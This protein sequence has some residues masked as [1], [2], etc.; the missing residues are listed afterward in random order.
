[1]GAEHASVR[2]RLIAHHIPQV[3]QHA[4]PLAVLRQHCGV[5][6]VWV[7]QNNVGLLSQRRTLCPGRVAIQHACTDNRRE[8]WAAL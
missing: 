2:V 8:A 7:R 4:P 1:M 5:Q 6:Q 3:A